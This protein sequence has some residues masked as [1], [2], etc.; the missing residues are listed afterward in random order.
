MGPKD[1]SSIID[2][3]PSRVSNSMNASLLLPVS[4]QEVKTVVFS[5]GGAKASGPDGIH[6]YLVAFIKNLGT[7]SN[8]TFFKLYK[9]FLFLVVCLGNGMKLLLFLSSR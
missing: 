6:D 2:C 1:F 4:L 9:A 5:L 8:L 7:S 3:I